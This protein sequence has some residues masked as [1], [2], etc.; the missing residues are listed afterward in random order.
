MHS[1]PS[2]QSDSTLS[3]EQV[4]FLNAFSKSCRYTT[5]AML[6]NSQSGHP[7]GSLSSLDYLALLYAYIIG[8]TGEK[9]VI[10]H[11]HISPAVYSVLAEMGYIDKDDV[12][13]N[14]RKIGSNFEGHITRHV[15]GILYGTGPLG[16]GGSVAIGMAIA[17]KLNNDEQKIYTMMGDGECDE[18]Q[19]YEMMQLAVKYKLNNLIAFVDY[20]KVQLSGSLDEVMPMNLRGHFE[21]AGWEVL[22]VD[23]HDYKAM[24]EILKKANQ[25]EGKPVVIL[26]NTIMGKGVS[27]MEKDGLELNSSWHG[28]APKPDQADLALKELELN[29]DELDNLEEY[30]REFI[31]WSP[32]PVVFTELLSKD[33]QINIGES[34][35]YPA[36]TVTDCRSAYGDALLDLAKLNNNVLAMT[37][38]LAGSVKTAGV[39][40]AFP[41]RHLEMGISEQN[42]VSVAGGLSMSDKIPFCSTFG[43]FMSSRAKGQARVNDINQ[44]N[45]KMVATHCGLSVGEDGPTH[46]AIDDMGSFLGFFNTFIIEPADAN[47]T[48]HIIRYVASHYGNFYVR[49]GRHK[50][51]VILKEDGTVFYDENYEYQYGKTDLIRSGSDITVVAS[52]AC[53]TE[54]MQAL[55]KIKELGKNI[56]VE[57]I[58]VSS[59]KKFDQGLID[60]IAKTKRVVTVEDHNPTSG[61]G[62]QIAKLI[63]ENDLKVDSFKMLGVTEYQL[64]GKSP[65]LYHVAGIDSD[66]VVE[67]CIDLM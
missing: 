42:M 54:A 60:S 37:A 24:W 38:D 39:K 5:I 11:G 17:A 18:G 23:G 3:T 28:N 62:G 51:P 57:I 45:V 19:V 48:D 63:L 46:Q 8:Q 35:L 25:V 66:A 59:I 58:A 6:K 61:L 36:G 64:S 1:I 65:E 9:I 29:S 33:N 31:K 14:F 12:I 22:E 67:A 47:Q 30:R 26:G 53:V 43:A 44:A 4:T 20:N 2:L 32:D 50:F 34:K 56:S 21:A 10:S 40:K 7:G 27:Y 13:E 16:I 55:D 52:G 41:D 49:M 15:P